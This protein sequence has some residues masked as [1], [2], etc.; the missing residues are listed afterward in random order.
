MA[1]TT[2]K[3]DL[4]DLMWAPT[5]AIDRDERKLAEQPIADE[6]SPHIVKPGPEVHVPGQTTKQ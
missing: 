3:P 5:T 4:R 6:D 2:K 1:D